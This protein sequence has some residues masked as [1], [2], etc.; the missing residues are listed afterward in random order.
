M[1]IEKTRVPMLLLHHMSNLTFDEDETLYGHSLKET[2]QLIKEI[3]VTRNKTIA[4]T[5]VL[6]VSMLVLLASLAWLGKFY[7]LAPREVP[8]DQLPQDA[9]EKLPPSARKLHE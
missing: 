5:A 6:V 3:K 9:K 4:G 1:F 2:P 8:Y 7:F